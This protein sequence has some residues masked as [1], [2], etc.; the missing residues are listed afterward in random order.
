MSDKSDKSNDQSSL[1]SDEEQ[2]Y[3]NNIKRSRK[4]SSKSRSRSRD[5][6]RRFKGKYQSRSHSQ[7]KMEQPS[8]QSYKGKQRYGHMKKQFRQK[9]T[10]SQ[11]NQKTQIFVPYLDGN[12]VSFRTFMENQSDKLDHDKALEVYKNYQNNWI[13]KQDDTF[14]TEHLNEEWF[15]EKYDAF[16]IEKLK[17]ERSLLAQKNAVIFKEKLANNGFNNIDFEYD[18]IAEEK[19]EQQDSKVNEDD[20]SIQQ[21][22]KQKNLYGEIQVQEDKILA[23][24]HAQDPNSSALFIPIIPKNISRWEIKEAI[25]HLTGFVYLSLSEPNKYHEY[26]RIGWIIFDTDENCK[27]AM[28]Q[29]QSFE[30]KNFHFEIKKSE[31]K[32]QILKLTK[33]M[34]SSRIQQDLEL[35]TNLIKTLNKEKKY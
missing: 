6:S 11:V 29:L 3:Q 20:G 4:S 9:G 33:Q 10:W 32:K 18:G 25:K 34:D 5:R 21:Q 35:T 14:C 19:E 16:L 22:G 15:C 26:Q 23:Q 28:G 8:Y 13:K 1:S 24:Y 27:K 30:L 12:L 2:N 31:S 17:N 7:D